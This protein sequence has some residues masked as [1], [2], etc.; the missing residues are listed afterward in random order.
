MLA[1]VRRP[2]EAHILKH[3]YKK[4]IPNHP[5]PNDSRRPSPSRSISLNF[6]KHYGRRSASTHRSSPSYRSNADVE[7]LDLDRSSPPS[8]I[9]APSP[10]RSLGLGMGIFTSHDH[11][12][13]LPAAFGPR[14]SSSYDTLPP[15]FYPSVSHARLQPPPRMTSLVAPTGFVPLS[16][17]VQYSASVMRAVHPPLPSPLRSTASRSHSHLPATNQGPNL[18]Y[19]ARYSRSSISLTRPHRLSSA[20]AGSVGWSSRSGST[21]PGDEGRRT[22]SSSNADGHDRPSASMIAYAIL[23]GTSI[24]GYGYPQEQKSH[25]HQRHSSAPDTTAGAECGRMAM[26]WKPKL[27]SSNEGT[28]STPILIPRA[29]SAELLSKF[30]PDTSPEDNN[31]NLRRAFERDLDHRLSMMVK[32]TRKSRSSSPLRH[33]EIPDGA[34]T[35]SRASSSTLRDPFGSG[36][37]KNGMW[38]SP[39]STGQS[40]R[41][42]T[43]DGGDSA[44]SSNTRGAMSISPQSTGGSTRR[45]TSTFD[46]VKNKPLP[47]IAAL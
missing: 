13:P 32:K 17:P 26:G 47:K 29:S 34:T 6:E 38:I 27:K 25:H 39:Q 28:D 37:S 20:P 4:P 7:T 14:R 42:L 43:F 2:F 18:N 24:P 9:H 31:I 1:S 36:A 33:S 12:P 44:A 35:V 16:A 19:R 46:D 45:L 3:G 30:S 23:N 41:R 22:P 40:S 11:P 15:V 21:G 8:T 5:S 10:V